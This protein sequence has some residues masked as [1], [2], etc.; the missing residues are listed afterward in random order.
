MVK[1]NSIFY[2][3]GKSRDEYK[4]QMKIDRTTTVKKTGKDRMEITTIKKSY[5]L[6]DAESGKFHC[7]KWMEHIEKAIAEAK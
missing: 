3:K 4:G 1:G 2:F 6:I 7:D 5:A